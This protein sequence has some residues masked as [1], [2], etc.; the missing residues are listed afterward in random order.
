MPGLHPGGL[1]SPG[2]LRAIMRHLHM[3]LGQGGQP[4][5]G[6]RGYGPRPP[7][8][9]GPDRRRRRKGNEPE[10]EPV[11]PDNPRPRSGGVEAPLEYDD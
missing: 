9:P 11:E 7:G 4:G 8:R 10:R 3:L 5:S 1:F 2:A 6:L